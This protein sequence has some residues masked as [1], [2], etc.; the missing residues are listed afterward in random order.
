MSVAAQP[1]PVEHDVTLDDAITMAVHFQRSGRTP[2]A[3]EIFDAVLGA[4]PDQ[5]A[6]L[7]Y[8]GLLAYQETGAADAVA[9]M[10][11]SVLLEPGIADWHS[12]LGV[13]LKAEGRLDEAEAAYRRATALDPDHAN[14]HHNLGVLLAATGR[15]RE[16]VRCYCRVITLRPLHGDARRLLAL[17]HSTL[18][19]TDKAVAIF[20]QWLAEEPDNPV[21]RHMLAACSGRNVP[22]RASDACVARIFDGFA[23]SFDAKLSNLHYRAPAL[24]AAVL[25]NTG[26][27]P[28]RDLH[29]LDAGCG[30]GLCG[31]LVTPWAGR[32]AGVD[33][34]GGMLA[35]ARERAID[36]RPLY[37]ELH[38]AELTAF[39][40]EHPGQF[41]VIVSADTLVYFGDLA[42]AFAAAATALRGHGRFVFTLEDAGDDALE[43]F[44]IDAHGRYAHRVDGVQRLLK[45]AGFVAEIVRAE[46]RMEAGVAVKGLVV[47]AARVERA[48]HG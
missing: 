46:L 35:R 36:G 9:R 10:E 48:T 45:D 34:S 18:G 22:S 16:A 4:V 15:V 41:D 44:H 43:P 29:I 2:E 28:K 39:L 37:D 17:A 11:R 40:R 25:E 33:L 8:G 1:E 47:S 32:L 14:A 12:N 26:L 42:E 3:R 19:E 7:H 27:E 21:V 23:S 20:E 24:V 5:P 13:V 6:A 30:T 38:Q 31:P